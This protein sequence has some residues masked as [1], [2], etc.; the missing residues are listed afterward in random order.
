MR[1]PGSV[2]LE[3][4]QPDA[5]SEFAD[6]GTAAHELAALAL[7]NG[8]DAAAYLGRIITVGER[9]FAV[10]AE[11]AGHV[12]MYVD[13]VRSFAGEL[14][15]EQAL[16]LQHITGEANAFGTA[17]AVVVD[18]DVLTVVDLKYGQGVLVDA[19]NNPQLQMYALAALREF[20]Y[21]GD[22]ASVRVAIVQPR[23]DHVSEC[24][25]TLAELEIFR[26]RAAAAAERTTLALQYFDKYGEM[27]DKYL[28]PG[29][30]QCR[31]CKAK[32][33]CPALTAHVLATVADDFVDVSQPLPPQL[34]PVESRTFDNATLGNLMSATDLIE[35]WCKAVRAKAESE[36]LAG[37]A[38]PGFKLV[39][40]RRGA[41]KWADMTAAEHALKAM[42]L[43]VDEMYDLSL[44]SPTTAEKLHK[45]GAIGP[46]QWPKLQTLVV[47]PEGRP[48]VAL[49][50]DKR[51]ALVVQATADEFSVVSDDIA[52]LV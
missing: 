6:E 52:E 36:L 45:A 19:E 31:F 10:D 7:A 48:S 11:M 30:S 34:K 47:Q 38:V 35:A 27:R 25:Y 43:K 46:R 37:N 26:Q 18:G 23:R 2:A 1:C 39:Q 9:G 22:F 44:I 32:A 51:P 50:S 17:D 4:G 3:S 12:Q 15:V 42:R 41:R 14:A 24:G 33:S 49:E 16:P 40:G 28:A 29:D 21:L 8:T 13:Y 20:D 5:S